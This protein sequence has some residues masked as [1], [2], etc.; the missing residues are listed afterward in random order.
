ME[1]YDELEIDWDLY[2]EARQRAEE[3]GIGI[4]EFIGRAINER[5]KTVVGEIFVGF[6]YTKMKARYSMN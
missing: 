2:E 6:E 1:E 5:Y 3:E 4:D